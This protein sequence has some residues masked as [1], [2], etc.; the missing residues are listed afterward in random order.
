METTLVIDGQSF[1]LLGKQRGGAAVYRGAG[2][3]LRI[4]E[5][6]VI[7]RDLSLHREMEKKKF[8]VAQIV[9]EGTH[10]SLAYFVE[11]SLGD[12]S[13]RAI[14]QKDME[15]SGAIAADNFKSFLSVSK[16][17]LV[18]QV[19][20]ADGN[21]DVGEFAGGIKLTTLCRELPAHA[22]EIRARFMH[23]TK[24]LNDLPKTLTHGDCNPA[25]MYRGGIIDL[26]DSFYG[27]LGYDIVSA[28]ISVEWSPERRDYEFPAYYRFSGEQKKEYLK[29]MDAVGK[30]A[31]VEKLSIYADELAFC[32]AVWLST[33]MQEW[34]KTQQW[35]FENFIDRYLS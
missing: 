10:G 25:N 8:P 15:E 9:Q 13:F 18:A 20:N 33:G 30:K 22:D 5:P 3:F 19:K 17:L 7:A 29:M 2:T 6:N 24:R 4:G 32:R 34:P 14:F 27:P 23:I 1:Q 35:R 11:L 31:G 12:A 26:E 21:W 28:L 16:Q